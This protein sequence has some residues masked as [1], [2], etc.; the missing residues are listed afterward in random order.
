VSREAKAVSVLRELWSDEGCRWQA[1]HTG[2]GHDHG[3]W[4]VTLE[5]TLDTLP[6]HDTDWVTLTW[7]FYG[8]SIAEA[9][10]GAAEWVGQVNVWRPCPE[11]DGQGEWNHARCADCEGTGL[12]DPTQ[13]ARPEEG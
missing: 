11:C 3:A 6:F 5:A 13:V 4:L 12:S 1:T 8:E 9:L 7:Q 10:E 2:Y